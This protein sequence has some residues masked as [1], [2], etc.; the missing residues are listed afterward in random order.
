MRYL[1][2]VRPEQIPDRESIETGD[3]LG[4][5]NVVHLDN[6]AFELW[7]VSRD[8][9]LAVFC[10]RNQQ[11]V[12]ADV[13]AVFF[14]QNNRVQ[15]AAKLRMQPADGWMVGPRQSARLAQHVR[16]IVDAAGHSLLAAA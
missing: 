8:G 4:S 12:I 13:L 7:F 3:N 5:H 2:F 11:H 6:A 1:K 16:H 9:R 15:T 14:D 10:R